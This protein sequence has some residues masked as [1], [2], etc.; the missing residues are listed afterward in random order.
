MTWKLTR[1]LTRGLLATSLVVLAS[2]CA[3]WD[4]Q[5]AHTVAQPK[6]VPVRNLTSFTPALQCMDTLFVSFGVSNVV[7][8]SAGIPDATG[9]VRTGTKDM[10][11]SAISRMSVKSNAFVFVDFDQS[12]A[13]VAELHSLVGFTEDFRVPSYYIRGAITQLD[14][15][16]IA[17]QVGGGVA[18]S[19]L[20]LGVS[21]DLVA[22]VVSI[23]MNVGKLVTR[24]IMPGIS[25]NNSIAVSRSGIGGDAGATIGKAGM[26]F[27]I[28]LNK[29]EGVHAATRTL[30]ELSAIEIL[31]KLVEVPYW[32]CLSIEQTHPEVLAE[33]R[34]WFDAMSEEERVTFT[35]RALESKGYYATAING[36]YDASTKAAVGR[37]QAE[38]G[39]IANG[40]LDFQLYQSLINEDLALGQRPQPV[41]PAAV[42]TS[43]PTP[44]TISLTTPKGPTPVY[45][46]NEI[47]EM[48]LR[49]SQDSYVY[50]YYRDDEA[51]I[52][53]I[54]PNRFSP[55]PYVVAGRSIP[56]LTKGSPFGI[57]FE[58]AGSREEILC[59]A[60]RSE[61]GLD[62]SGTLKAAD[63]TPI[64]V[65]SLEEISASFKRA[66]R[67]D[68]AEARLPISVVAA[69]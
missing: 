6:T 48:N 64:P 51:Q 1:K 65:D 20:Q 17:N 19:D 46:V 45:A 27:N 52:A 49:A 54:F 15:S 68:V 34:A 5:T 18:I 67:D 55:D 22:S 16:V 56:V 57:E 44:L 10:L 42:Q 13:D 26:F 62:V 23:D 53:R 12:Q 37:Y 9:E 58:V 2:A 63:L 4:P 69:N 21:K 8:T 66:G 28:S 32:R 50:C 24:Q 36:V 43:A 31:G 39:L 33:A 41:E 14:S 40:R 47:L 30:V 60:A 11:I 38:N 7:I 3:T 29:S 59:I 61:R 35:Q 25:A